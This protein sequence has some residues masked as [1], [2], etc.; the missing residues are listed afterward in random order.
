[1]KNETEL[2]TT[3][4]I[5]SKEFTFKSIVEYVKINELEIL[6]SYKKWKSEHGFITIEDVKSINKQASLKI[7]TYFLTK[8][9]IDRTG[10]TFQTQKADIRRTKQ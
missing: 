2:I 10:E 7:R 1:M 4:I 9:K 5:V 6:C 3:N 8:K